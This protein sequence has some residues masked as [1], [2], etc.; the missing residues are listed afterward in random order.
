MERYVEMLSEKMVKALNEQLNAEYYSAY[1]YLS[2]SAYFESNNYPGFAKWMNVQFQEEQSHAE[3]LFR[4]I[5][6]RGAKV[7]LKEI[8]AP[9]TEFESVMAVFEQTL[10]HEQSVTKSIDNLTELAISEKDHAS[11]TYLQ[12]YVSE[13]IEEEKNVGDILG[14]LKRAGNAQQILF[15]L[16]QQLGQRVFVEPTA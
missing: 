16:D 12:W 7:T 8:K 10:I 13:Q 2:M 15:M 9:P 1:L 4:Y 3:K 14:T 11:Q 5:N 6:D